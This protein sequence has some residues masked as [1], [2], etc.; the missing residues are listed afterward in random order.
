MRISKIIEDQNIT[1]SLAEKHLT[2]LKNKRDKL[3]ELQILFP[4]AHYENG[5]VCLPDVWDKVNCMRIEW[6]YHYQTPQIV[7]KFSLGKRTTP[8]NVPEGMN[9]HIYPFH[10]PIANIQYIY[11]AT[12]KSR[13]REVTILNYK[14]LIPDI[15]PKKEAFIKR[16]KSRL[17]DFI[18]VEKMRPTNNSF[19]YEEFQ[20]LVLLG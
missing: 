14:K 9:I 16:I 17:M 5:V 4:N 12:S 8:E 2:S 6:Q 10:N 11:D 1:I 20:R 3:S 13:S 18:L 19:E 7:A 15:C